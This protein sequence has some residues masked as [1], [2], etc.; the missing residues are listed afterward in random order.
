V[1]VGDGTG[2]K[3]AGGQLVEKED[4]LAHLAHHDALTGL[5]N[6]LGLERRLPGLIEAAEA[7]HWHVAFLYLDIDHFKKIND[8]RGHT[9]GDRLL[10]IAAERL[11]TCLSAD[12]LIVRMGG[13][14]VVV[15]S[16]ELRATP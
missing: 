16:S 9:V 11:R 6:R 14:D 7:G 1:V 8:L 3:E 12:D 15:A 10:Q 13:G 2:G 4:R 5:L